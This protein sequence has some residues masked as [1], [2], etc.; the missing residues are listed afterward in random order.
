MSWFKFE[1]K[2]AKQDIQN[3]LHYL[4][5]PDHKIAVL[6]MTFKHFK[7][8]EINKVIKVLSHP[9]VDNC[10]I[11]VIRFGQRKFYE[12]DLIIM[13]KWILNKFSTR[14]EENTFDIRKYLFRFSLTQDESVDDMVS[15]QASED[16]Q[17]ELRR[18]SDNR[19]SHGI[20][21]KLLYKTDEIVR[22]SQED[23]TQ[24]V[25]DIDRTLTSDAY[26]I[27]YLIYENTEEYVTLKIGNINYLKEL[28]PDESKWCI[29][30]IIRPFSN[31]KNYFFSYEYDREH[32]KR[33]K[34]HWLLKLAYVTWI[35]NM[36][37]CILIPISMYH[38]KC[39]KG[40]LWA[41]HYIFG[42]YLV[43]SYIFE[44]IFFFWLTDARQQK[45]P[46][47]LSKT[48][49]CGYKLMRM[50]F[51]FGTAFQSLISKAAEY[52]AISFMVEI[53]K[54][55]HSE[56][57]E[58]NKIILLILF[59]VSIF[60][61]ILTILFPVIV[62][63]S[64]IVKP[65]EDTFYPLTAHTARL[66]M[67]ADLK[68]LSRYVERYA[69]NYYGP[70]L[71]WNQPTFIT[72][73]WFKLIFEDMIDLVIQLLFISYIHKENTGLV[74]MTAIGFTGSSIISSFMTIYL[75]ETSELD[76]DN[77]VWIKHFILYNTARNN[78]ETSNNSSS[79]QRSGIFSYVCKLLLTLICFF[80]IFS[81]KYS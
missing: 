3:L 80:N 61:F 40:L 58:Y 68:L 56:S 31:A 36:F 32:E 42:S 2:L 43:L 18:N 55:Y 49:R 62:F 79:F 78:D 63:I 75:K 69:I 14:I 73:S 72:L 39:L 37:M 70:L 50:Y 12:K 57:V 23:L 67:C 28:N 54:C 51:I 8:S 29:S 59:I 27:I 7:Q 64:L 20:H 5:H 45:L 77:L 21:F 35:T 60:T 4:K 81:L 22:T 46:Q 11:D 48:S 53:I 38:D 10:R 74:L 6:D 26:K 44:I 1:G 47:G 9:E 30:K 76:H 17:R 13:G 66:L 65:P 24:I 15:D 33:V 52:T 16:R 71:W 34:Y 41:A 25:M 19:K